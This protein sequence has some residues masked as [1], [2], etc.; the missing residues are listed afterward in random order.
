MGLL[1]R[2]RRPLIHTLSPD[3]WRSSSN[4][5]DAQRLLGV[6][7][8]SVD[9]PETVIHGPGGPRQL[10]WS[11]SGSVTGP[12]PSEVLVRVKLTCL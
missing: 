8:R 9:G 1:P 5:S 10:P 7:V 11:G 2:Q 4:V 6:V 12:P 3:K